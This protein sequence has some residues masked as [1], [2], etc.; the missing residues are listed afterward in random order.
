MSWPSPKANSLVFVGEYIWLSPE[1]PKAMSVASHSSVYFSSHDQFL[2][3]FTL[4]SLNFYLTHF[5]SVQAMSSLQNDFF[6]S[7]VSPYLFSALC[8]AKSLFLCCCSSNALFTPPSPSSPWLFFFQHSSVHQHHA[9][10]F[11]AKAALQR[12]VEPPALA[13]AMLTSHTQNVVF[14]SE[15]TRLWGLQG[16]FAQGSMGKL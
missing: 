7:S 3:F 14:A 1:S 10:K 2:V 9:H 8:P 13:W 12:Q 16:G 4:L 15:D 5:S 6:H 11:D